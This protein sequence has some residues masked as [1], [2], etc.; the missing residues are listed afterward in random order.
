MCGIFG[1]CYG[2]GGAAAEEW[3]PIDLMTIMFPAIVHRGPHAYGWMFAM[4]SGEVYVQKYAGR[5]DTDQALMNMEAFSISDARWI[6]GH[7]RFATKG[8]PKYLGNNHPIS[9]GDIVGVHNGT[10]HDWEP[11]IEE[12]GRSDPKAKVDSEAIFAAVNKWGHK[13]GLKR[14]QGAMVAVYVNRHYPF[15]LH[16]ARNSGRELYYCKTQAGSLM[17][18]SEPEVVECTDLEIKDFDRVGKNQLLT[19]RNGRIRERQTFQ[20]VADKVLPSEW[21]VRNPKPPEREDRRAFRAFAKE[22]I[23]QKEHEEMLKELFKE[24]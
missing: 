4:P 14:I 2:P 13:G 7:V 20:P 23:S 16:I 5:S 18:A 8:S 22:V 1:V 24:I 19:V 6:V 3:D 9:H 12:T 21:V 10:L 17:F 15:T 11:I